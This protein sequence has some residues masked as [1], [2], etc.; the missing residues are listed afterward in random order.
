MI[1]GKLKISKKA[2][3]I[4]S[5]EMKGKNIFKSASANV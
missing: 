1:V 5:L 4:S 3:C 2:K